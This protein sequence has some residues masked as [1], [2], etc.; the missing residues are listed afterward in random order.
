MMKI[1]AVKKPMAKVA[2]ILLQVIAP[3]L[4]AVVAIVEALAII[5]EAMAQAVAHHNIHIMSMV[6][7]LAVA[8]AQAI[9]Q[10]LQP[11][12]MVIVKALK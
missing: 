10:V 7:V 3:I 5:A 9:N 8:V 12:P 6:V 2:V 1:P 4:Q 11:I